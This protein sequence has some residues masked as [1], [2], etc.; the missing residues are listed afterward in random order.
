MNKKLKVATALLLALSTGQA[1]AVEDSVDVKVTGDIVP[2]ACVPTVSG[3]ATFDFGTIKAA[4]LKMDAENGMTRKNLQFSVVCSDSMKVAFKPSDGRVGT[5][6]GDEGTFGVGMVDNKK[7]GRYNLFMFTD[8]GIN[9]DGRTDGIAGLKSYDSGLTW[10]QS[11]L[12]NKLYFD[13]RPGFMSSV[14]IKGSNTP[15]AFKSMTGTLNLDLT[16]NKGSELDLTKVTPINGL[17]TIQL[18]YL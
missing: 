10:E 12:W 11:G 17:A 18:I 14:S 13:P 5:S 3:G 15:L 16:L 8:S 1:S 2:P 6:S 4:S 7:V 9:V